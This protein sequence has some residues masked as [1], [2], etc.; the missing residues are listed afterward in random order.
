MKRTPDDLDT[1][2]A[3]VP[4][5]V[6]LV[7]SEEYGRTQIHLFTATG[8]ARP[9]VVAKRD[10][11]WTEEAPRQAFEAHS[12]LS[13][14][15]APFERVTAPLAIAWSPEPPVL[16]MERAHGSAVSHLLRDAAGST[17]A[18]TTAMDAVGLSGKALAA[19]H[20]HL[21]AP[22]QRDRDVVGYAKR[23]YRQR[24]DWA[25]SSDLPTVCRA[26]D[27]ST[28]NQFYSS[29]HGLTLI[30]PP[31]KPQA[32]VPH[33]DVGYYLSSIV[34]AVIGSNSVRVRRSATRLNARLA[35]E[36][37]SAYSEAG[38]YDLRGRR[39]RALLGLVAGYHSAN[40]SRRRWKS[41]EHRRASVNAAYWAA[42]TYVQP[43]AKPWLSSTTDGE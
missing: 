7:R 36:F 30:D 11:T 15:L 42:K 9:D 12:R 5:D 23:M 1:L 8:E 16:V 32:T 6:R 39:D 13:A 22:T 34:H 43:G 29:D 18:S 24:S 41:G 33:D 14:A 17:S 27:Y 25:K 35:E 3:L 26:T 2:T 31:Y 4:W 10:V 21:E 28:S 19:L 20:A 38:P 37:L 40:W